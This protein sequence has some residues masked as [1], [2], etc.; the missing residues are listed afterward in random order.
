[1]RSLL[2]RSLN[3]LLGRLFGLKLYSIRAHGREDVSDIQKTGKEISTIFDIGAN[4]GQSA[5][6]FREAFPLA[7]IHCFEPASVQYGNLVRRLSWDKRVR[8]HRVAVG[9]APG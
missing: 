8:C 2:R 1:M 6:K 9:S 7:T 4:E 3:K 5:V